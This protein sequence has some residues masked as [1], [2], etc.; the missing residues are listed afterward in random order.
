MEPN[1][2]NSHEFIK[3]EENN[4]IILTCL[5]IYQ[6]QIKKKPDKIVA[7]IF[8]KKLSKQDKEQLRKRLI[9]AYQRIVKNRKLQSELALWDSISGDGLNG[10]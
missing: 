5:K 6:Y 1:N 8:D 7:E 3:V 10:K 4:K 9:A 2:H